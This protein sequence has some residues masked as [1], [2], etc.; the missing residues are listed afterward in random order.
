[1]AV[2]SCRDGNMALWATMLMMGK[3]LTPQMKQLERKL[4]VEN[5]LFYAF[6]A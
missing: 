2:M 1:M 3:F 4:R 5:S 6:Y